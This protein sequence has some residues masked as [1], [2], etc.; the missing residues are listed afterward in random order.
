MEH[1]LGMEETVLIDLLAQTNTQQGKL[2]YNQ[3]MGL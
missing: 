1:K 2:N 3:D